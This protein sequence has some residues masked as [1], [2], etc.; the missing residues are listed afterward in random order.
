MFAHWWCWS[1]STHYITRVIINLTLFGKLCRRDYIPTMYVRGIVT[2]ICLKRESTNARLLARVLFFSISF[3]DVCVC[4]TFKIQ[5]FH[6]CLSMSFCQHLFHYKPLFLLSFVGNACVTS[7]THR[8]KERERERWKRE[9][10]C[11]ELSHIKRHTLPLCACVCVEYISKYL[12][13]VED[14]TFN[15]SIRKDKR[16]NYKT[17]EWMNETVEIHTHW[18]SH[19]NNNDDDNDDN[20]DIKS[21]VAHK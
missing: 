2:P 9:N 18:Y 11:N 7:F 5:T 10:V 21:T 14:E 8:K 1:S 17:N 15:G 3:L 20:D 12:V 13:N 6:W 19:S 16:L 4:A